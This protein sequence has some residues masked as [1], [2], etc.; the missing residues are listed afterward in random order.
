LARGRG[1]PLILVNV[2]CDVEEN[3]QR[4]GSD[5][6]K[7][8]GKTKLIDGD[9]L[10]QIREEARL[11]D[12]EI[13]L[14]VMIGEGNAFYF[15][16]DSTGLEVEIATSKLWELLSEVDFDYQNG[17]KLSCVTRLVLELN[18]N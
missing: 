5:E 3:K 6:R 1:V 18:W 2:L 10:E 7:E 15:D 13:V 11:L 17:E 8:G 12:R 9:V 4:L 16:L 14:D